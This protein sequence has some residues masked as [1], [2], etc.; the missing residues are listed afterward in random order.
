MTACL[1]YGSGV[2]SAG[3][4]YFWVPIVS[5]FCGSVTGAFLYDAFVYTGVTPV[6]TPWFGL[7]QFMKPHRV[8]KNRIEQQ[9]ADGMV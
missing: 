6:N 1:G 8:I 3:N 4:Y 2:W 9:E 5:P 7:K